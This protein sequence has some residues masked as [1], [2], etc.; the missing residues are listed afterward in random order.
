[1]PPPGFEDF[2]SVISKK[3]GTCSSLASERLDEVI[4]KAFFLINI[5]LEF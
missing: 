3:T 1:M 2:N 5:F 4:I